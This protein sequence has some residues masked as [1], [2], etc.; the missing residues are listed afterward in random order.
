MNNNEIN[1]LVASID[2]K[3][4]QEFMGKEIPVVEGGFGEGKRC[5]TDKT[6]AEI[7][8]QPTPEIRRRINDNAK[9]FK[10]DIDII[11]LKV[12]AES[13]NNLELLQPLGYSK[14]QI[15]KA[16]HIY[17]LSERG[18]AKLIKIMD[19][20]L[21]WDIHDK[22]IDEY[23]AMRKV[24]NSDEQLKSN[25]LLEIYNGGQGGILASKKLTELETRPLQDTIEKQ[26]NTINELLPA[27]NYTKKVLEDNNTLLT[28]T[29]I[30]KD[31]G[32]SG[33]ALNDLLHDLG[34]QY[35]QNGQWLLYSKYQ[36]KGYARTVQSEVK[37][38][39][40]QTKWTQKGKKF[41]HDILRKNGIKTVWEQQ[42]EV[43]QVEQQSFNLN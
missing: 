19:T 41:I 32:M 14:M 4:K 12:M 20:D 42:Q 27:A 10:T 35:K 33:H 28:I 5:L 43:L 36:G 15:S 38:A 29:Q 39:K 7:H 21:A 23:F 1:N 22:L 9:R 8:N 11:D 6:I 3:G 34:V 40:P 2:V 31:F 16:E 30:A 37:N 26:S 18:Y 24:I 13:H 25:L 17:L